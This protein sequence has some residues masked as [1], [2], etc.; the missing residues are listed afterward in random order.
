MKQDKLHNIPYKLI[1]ESDNIKADW[2][3]PNNDIWGQRYMD[4]KKDVLTAKRNKKEIKIIERYI[5]NKKTI[6]DIPCGY[7]RISNILAAKGYNVTGVDINKFFIDIAINEMKAKNLKVNYFVD[8]LI[9]Y[10]TKNKYNIVLNIFTSIGYYESEAKN[11]Q[12]INHLCR[13]VKTGG[14]LIIE[15][16]NPIY[17]LKN[18]K[19]K[20]IKKSENGTETIFKNFFDSKTST[21]ITIITEKYPDRKTKKLYNYI[22]LFFPHEL[23]NICLNNNLILKDLLNDK[24]EYM[25]ITNSKRMWLIFKKPYEK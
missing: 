1:T 3:L 6:L 9:K 8:D 5:K 15:T 24:G 14:Y 21:N 19:N 2:Y 18:F 16:I 23:I 17:L 13:L 12:S 10:K 4:E 7:G 20:I 11:I 25:D 22:R